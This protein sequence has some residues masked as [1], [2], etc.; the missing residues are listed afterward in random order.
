MVQEAKL[1]CDYIIMVG[2]GNVEPHADIEDIQR[3]TAAILKIIST[4]KI[5]ISSNSLLDSAK[6]CTESKGDYFELNKSNCQ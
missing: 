5:K 3:S 1:W 6:Q 4:D 2:S